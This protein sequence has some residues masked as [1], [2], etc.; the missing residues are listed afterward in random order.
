[1]P[2]T[3]M[4]KKLWVGLRVFEDKVD[5]KITENNGFFQEYKGNYQKLKEKYNNLKKSFKHHHGEVLETTDM[6][7]G[8][9]GVPYILDK[10]GCANVGQVECA[11][12]SAPTRF[13]ETNWEAVVA[14]YEEKIV[15]LTRDVDAFQKNDSGT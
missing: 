4:K 6:P 3:D 15:T 7:S 14:S 1:M 5:A 9:S 11:F 13:S 10:G 8:T 12:K 2:S